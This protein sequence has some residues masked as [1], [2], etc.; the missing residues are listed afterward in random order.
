M[1]ETGFQN[2]DARCGNAIYEQWQ[3]PQWEEPEL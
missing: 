3:G 2:D 1:G